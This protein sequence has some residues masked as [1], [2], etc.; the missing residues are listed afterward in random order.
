MGFLSGQNANAR[1]GAIRI[2]ELNSPDSLK[3]AATDQVTHT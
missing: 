2:P 1:A 3:R